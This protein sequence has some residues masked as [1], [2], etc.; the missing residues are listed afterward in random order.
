[1]LIR[2]L[3]DAKTYQTDVVKKDSLEV[4]ADLLVYFIKVR[5]LL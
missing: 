3:S 2:H 5:S 4:R 1:M